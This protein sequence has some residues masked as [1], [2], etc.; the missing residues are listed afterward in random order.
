MLFVYIVGFPSMLERCVSGIENGQIAIHLLCNFLSNLSALFSLYYH[1]IKILTVN[2]KKK[3]LCCCCEIRLLK[4]IWQ[5]LTRYF[6]FSLEPKIGKYAAFDAGFACTDLLFEGT[7]CH[8]LQVFEH[9]RNWT[10]WPNVN[11]SSPD[12]KNQTHLP[13]HVVFDIQATDPIEKCISLILKRSQ[14]W[15]ELFKKEKF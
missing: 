14:V 12:S 5:I 6:S 15:F 1:R 11:T 13:T 4:T 8:F 7:A 2:D 9:P 3:I 10:T